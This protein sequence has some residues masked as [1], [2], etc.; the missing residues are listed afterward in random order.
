[1]RKMRTHRR[2]QY[3]LYSGSSCPKIM[4]YI[5]VICVS[6]SLNTGH[7]HRCRAILTS[8]QRQRAPHYAMSFSHSQYYWYCSRVSVLIVETQAVLDLKLFSQRLQDIRMSN[9][10]VAIFS[11]S[12]G[13]SLNRSND[14][15]PLIQ[16]RILPLYGV[17]NG[18]IDHIWTRQ[19]QQRNKL[20]AKTVIFQFIASLIRPLKSTFEH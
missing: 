18:N 13:A 8:W 2:P 20:G 15:F 9:D 11:D 14:V 5:Q 4:H 19:I 3:L 16:N 10:V 6:I 17:L 12:F 7:V 1:M